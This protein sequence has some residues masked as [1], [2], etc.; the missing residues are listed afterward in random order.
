MKDECYESNEEKIPQVVD[1]GLISGTRWASCNLGASQPW[2]YGGYYAWGE[3]EEKDVYNS[4][5]FF[6]FSCVIL[7]FRNDIATFAMSVK[8]L[9]RSEGRNVRRYVHVGVNK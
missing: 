2:E 5:I 9:S 4:T 6:Q 8:L 7:I 1:L 3:T